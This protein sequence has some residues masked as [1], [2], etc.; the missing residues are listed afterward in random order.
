MEF[1]TLLNS[2]CRRSNSFF[3]ILKRAFWKLISIIKRLSLEDFRKFGFL[4]HSKLKIILNYIEFA[5]ACS[6]ILGNNDTILKA[7]YSVQQQKVEFTF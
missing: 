1:K 4:L 6:L 2:L 5:H 7:Q 3:Y